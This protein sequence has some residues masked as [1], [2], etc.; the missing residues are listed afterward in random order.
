M[1]CSA[2]IPEILKKYCCLGWVMRLDAIGFR[3]R[4]VKAITE[5]LCGHSFSAELDHDISNRLD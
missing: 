1:I 4:K 2:R 5:E 3:H